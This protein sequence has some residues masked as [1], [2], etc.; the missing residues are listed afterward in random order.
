MKNYLLPLCAALLL[1]PSVAFAAPASTN[2]E[3]ATV[4]DDGAVRAIIFG[5]DDEIEGE[6]L[7]PGGV[8]VGGAIAQVHRSMIGVRGEFIDKLIALSYDI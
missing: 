3:G 1:I 2:E 5:T 4:N 8:Q 6:V 7:K